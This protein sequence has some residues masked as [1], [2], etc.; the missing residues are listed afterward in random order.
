M[1]TPTYNEKIRV[2]VWHNAGEMLDYADLFIANVPELPN[3]HDVMN[4]AA[5]HSREGRMAPMWFN[6]YGNRHKEYDNNEP[7][8][9]STAFMGRVLMSLHL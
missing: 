1:Y 6:L 2:T 4:I 8:L 3:S 7:R 5:L 9:Y